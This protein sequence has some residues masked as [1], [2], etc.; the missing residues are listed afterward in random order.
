MSSEQRIAQLEAENAALK[1]KLAEY[2]SFLS[3]TIDDIH[4]K[5]TKNEN[6]LTES[7]E[8]NTIDWKLIRIK[9]QQ[10][11]DEYIMK[12][13]NDDIINVTDDCDEH[14]DNIWSLAC[15]YGRIN[16]VKMCVNLGVDISNIKNKN[17][18][19]AS[20]I[21]R[22]YNQDEILEYLLLEKIGAGKANDIVNSCDYMWNENGVLSSFLHQLNKKQFDS[23]KPQIVKICTNII[24]NRDPISSFLINLSMSLD[25]VTTWNSVK[26]LMDEI[27]NDTHDSIGWYYLNNYLLKNNTFLFRK[28]Q[29][30]SNKIK[31]DT[32]ETK[33]D[34][35]NRKV[36]ELNEKKK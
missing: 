22:S 34:N 19:D 30:F 14:G 1:K 23:L 21:A 35:T 13:I 3:D 33:D 17:G 36:E 27:I 12:L 15:Q 5:E 4:Q 7:K 9:Y 26:H 8:D 6:Q 18:Y 10:E 25:S 11:D 28:Y 16:I 2:D 31:T 32:D 20:H 24:E 29:L